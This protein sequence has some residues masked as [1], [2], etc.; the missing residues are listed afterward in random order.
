MNFI[1]K[2]QRGDV[3]PVSTTTSTASSRRSDVNRNG[4]NRYSIVYYADTIPLFPR[5]SDSSLHQNNHRN[6]SKTKK[7][8]LRNMHNI[9]AVSDLGCLHRG[10]SLVANKVE[11]KQKAT[12]F[13]TVGVSLSFGVPEP[14]NRLLVLGHRTR[15]KLIQPS[16]S[17]LISSS[18]PLTSLQIFSFRLRVRCVL[19]KFLRATFSPSVRFTSSI[20]FLRSPCFR[21]YIPYSPLFE[22]HLHT[23]PPQ[24]NLKMVSSFKVLMGGWSLW[25]TP[26]EF[27]T[28]RW[29]N[30]RKVVRWL[31]SEKKTTFQSPQRNIPPLLLGFFSP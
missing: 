1:V 9:S 15:F 7:T 8:N 19:E 29:M 24:T 27:F 12:S 4:F 14:V 5:E 10:R 2:H 30:H 31:F 22:E 11:G 21:I 3:L 13:K 25:R 23:P 18:G 6:K 26:G 28:L 17:S 20:I 16:L